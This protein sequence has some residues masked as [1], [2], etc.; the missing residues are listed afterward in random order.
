[1]VCDDAAD[2]DADDDD[3]EDAAAVAAAAVVVVA[4]AAPGNG[5]FSMGRSPL[6]QPPRVGG[7]QG[8]FTWLITYHSFYLSS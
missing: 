1:M 5:L 6:R 8:G 4:V 3:D 2:D 7:G